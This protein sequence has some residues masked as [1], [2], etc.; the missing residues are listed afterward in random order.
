MTAN[1]Y[2]PMKAVMLMKYFKLK[3]EITIMTDKPTV[4]VQSHRCNW[5][6]F[7]II[8][9]YMY[10]HILSLRPTLAPLAITKLNIQIEKI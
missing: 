1:L 9:P 7:L 5:D 8:Y 6:S 4:C 3:I 2:F 10:V